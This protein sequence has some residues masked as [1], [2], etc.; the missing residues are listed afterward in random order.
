SQAA[1]LVRDVCR[2]NKVC[3]VTCAGASRDKAS[4]S[5]ERDCVPA[6]SQNR[7]V[8]GL[9]FNRGS[10]A[11]CGSEGERAANSPVLDLHRPAL[12]RDALSAMRVGILENALAPVARRSHRGRRRRFGP[13][14][15][16]KWSWT[17]LG[18]IQ[19]F[20]VS[21][22]HFP[23]KSDT[24]NSAAHGTQR[25]VRITA[26]VRRCGHPDRKVCPAPREFE[27]SSIRQQP[28]ADHVTSASLAIPPRRAIVALRFRT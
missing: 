16:I 17:L 18:H 15:R 1:S 23:E 25:R 12:Y 28:P 21:S 10:R 4:V 2:V 5:G 20:M 8:D 27:L 14:S 9:G 13:G 19:E 7:L 26:D 11:A 22:E 6:L 3:I 24:F